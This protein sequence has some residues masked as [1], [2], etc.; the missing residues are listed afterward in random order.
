MK[1]SRRARSVIRRSVMWASGMVCVLLVA[2]WVTSL[3]WTIFRMAQFGDAIGLK[4]GAI[5]Y[6]WT[7]EAKRASLVQRFGS[8]AEMH[9]D[10]Y[11][12]AR[13][14][15]VE[16]WPPVGWVSRGGRASVTIML[17]PAA[18]VSGVSAGCLLVIGRR[19]PRVGH[20]AAC[21]YDLGGLAGGRACPECG[22]TDGTAKR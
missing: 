7:T 13:K 4:S 16:W 21:G 14:T 5:F 1:L 9:W 15:P 11:G 12:G 22:A 18:V 2:A 20:C 8:D 3:W 17:W 6:L 10:W 19:G